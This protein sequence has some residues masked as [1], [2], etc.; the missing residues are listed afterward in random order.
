MHCTGLPSEKIHV[1]FYSQLN[2]EENSSSRQEEIAPWSGIVKIKSIQDISEDVKL[3]RLN[4]PSE[5]PF[6]YNP[7]AHLEISIPQKNEKF[8]ARNYSISS[9]PT[10]SKIPRVCSE[11]TRKRICL[12]FPT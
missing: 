3:F 7:G 5:I 9:S 4:F 12:K 6:S 2:K 8:I 10:E 11:K 1:R